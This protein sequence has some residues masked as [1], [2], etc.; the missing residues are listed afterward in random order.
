MPAVQRKDPRIVPGSEL[1]RL[2]AAELKPFF[3]RLAD[4]I[5][6]ARAATA[7]APRPASANYAADRRRR[8]DLI[9]QF[10]ISPAEAR[11]HVEAG[12]RPGRPAGPDPA[13]ETAQLRAKRIAW[14]TRTG[15]SDPRELERRFAHALA[16]NKV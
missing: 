7:P 5:L 15:I 4:A 16:N 10:G 13:A 8:I 14:A 11:R 2:V 6:A 3:A 12:T 1:K 9:A